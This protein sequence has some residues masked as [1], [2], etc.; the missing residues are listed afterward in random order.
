[1][2]LLKGIYLAMFH[3]IANN[4]PWYFKYLGGN[5]FRNFLF[6]KITGSG[7]NASIGRG[8]NI[9]DIAKLIKTGDNVVIGENFRLVGLTEPVIIGN[10]VSIAF[11]CVMITNQRTY[12][13]VT[14]SQRD[15]TYTSKK[16]IIE[17]EVVIGGGAY[18]MKGV[19]I[20]KGAYVGARSLVTKDVPP[21]MLVAGV[22]AKVI[23]SFRGE[24]K[25]TT[26][27]QIEGETKN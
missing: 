26:Q 27:D 1:M 9:M 11:D 12:G 21:Y 5:R 4:L 19:R 18:V 3:V 16:I 7:K 13:D 22:P 6:R 23:K 25:D 14:K 8:S 2:G 17:D 10:N 24:N 15:H 20:G